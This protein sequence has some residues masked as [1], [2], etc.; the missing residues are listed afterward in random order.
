MTTEPNAR[1]VALITGAGSGIGRAVAEMLHQHGY[2][3][4]LLGRRLDALNETKAM[5]GGHALCLT[6]DVAAPGEMRRAVGEVVRVLGRLDVLVNNAGFAANCPITGHDELTIRTTLDINT[7]A[8]AIAIAAAWN[9]FQVQSSGCIVNISSM[10]AL[11]PFPGFFAYAASKAAMNMLTKVAA[12]EGE[13]IG[14][15]AFAVCPG[16]VETPMLRGLFSTAQVPTAA[17]PE[18]V[19]AVVIDCIKGRHDALNGGAVLVN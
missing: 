3:L 16:A 17:T 15:R 1:P 6:C 2:R 8:P 14:V 7:A 4:G 11:D 12:S 9:Q 13:A 19:A 18:S 5:C 10:A